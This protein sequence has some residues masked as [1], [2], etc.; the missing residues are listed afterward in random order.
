MHPSSGATLATCWAPVP[1]PARWVAPTGRLASWSPVFMGG[2][3]WGWCRLSGTER[4]PGECCFPPGA[5]VFPSL[6]QSRAYLSC[7]WMGAR[8]PL[9]VTSLSRS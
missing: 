5:S 1:L 7:R 6:M 8:R 3:L 9:A 2:V 4:V